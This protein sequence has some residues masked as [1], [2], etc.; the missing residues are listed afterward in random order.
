M[1]NILI[2]SVLPALM[3][4]IGTCVSDPYPGTEPETETR[5]V[6]AVQAP[7][8]AD[9]AD[10]AFDDPDLSF[11]LPEELKE[12]SG[13]TA[14]PNGHLGAVQDEEGI[15]FV[16]NPETGAIEARHPFGE[17]GDYEGIE[18]VG[19][20]VY[21]LQS[22]GTLVELTGWMETTPKT[23]TYH[24]GLKGKNDTEG[25]G[26]DAAKG[27]LLIACKENP[28]D[29]MDDDQKA[30]YAYDLASSTLSSEPAYVLDLKTLEEE[31]GDR[32][33]FKPSAVAVHPV[34]GAIYVLSATAHALVVLE[35][36]GDVQT[37]WSL[38]EAIFE[39]PE[40]LAFL[41]DGTLFIASE[42]K[43]EPAMLHQFAYKSF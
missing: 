11:A 18:Q 9:G 10:Y 36:T 35:S 27:H 38:S 30:I 40:G 6:V 2:K 41:P 19:D 22:G 21:V 24:T 20:K 42:G 32:G 34:S 17:A 3:L 4:L 31:L 37:T 33:K 28:G 13:L 8:Q 5:P 14:L 1:T 15:L 25:L 16:L 7:G 12:I 43:K 26:Y 23:R 29:N 39:Q